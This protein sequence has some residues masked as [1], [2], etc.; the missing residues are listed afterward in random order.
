MIDDY[1]QALEKL[2]HWAEQAAEAGWLSRDDI[3]P[4]E[5]QDESQLVSLFRE[6]GEKPL[7]V[8]FFGGTGVGKSSLLNRL[9]GEDIA[10]TGVQRP[11]S[12]EVTLY[13]HRDFKDNLLPE[14]LPTEHTRIAWHNQDKRRFVAWLDLPDMDSTAREN[15]ALVEAW[16]PYIDWL[17]YVVSP[18]RYHDDLG[19]R[20][21]Q[22][23]G[24][25]HAWLFVMNHWDEGQPEQLEDFRDKLI[26]ENFS[27]PVILRTSCGKSIPD[28]DFPQLE[29]II[30]DAI[31]KHGLALLQS[32]GV[33]ARIDAARDQLAAW[34]ARLDDPERWQAAHDAW[35]Q[36]GQ[37]A[38]AQLADALKTSADALTLTLKTQQQGAAKALKKQLGLATD[39]TPATLTQTLWS[40][41]RHAALLD[42]LSLATGAAP[43]QSGLPSR[44]VEQR[45]KQ[46]RAQA[47]EIVRDNLQAALETALAKPGTPWQRLLYKLMDALSWLLPLAAASWAVFYLANTFRWGTLGEKAFLGID[48]AVHSGMMIAL[49]WF[50]P[51]WIK[52]RI[53]PSVVA[54]V[55]R[56]L[57]DGVTAAREALRDALETIWREFDEERRQIVDQIAAREETIGQ[58]KTN[59]REE[60]GGLIAEPQG[61][62]G[63]P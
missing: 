15:A 11:T 48:F 59:A 43:R 23:R 30:N 5:R 24:G 44:P 39:L 52:R 12:M 38:L 42:D 16:L 50:I 53:E 35:R 41:H 61:G 49:A 55:Q 25:R 3:A 29:A 26:Q 63:T 57:N 1:R 40:D 18:E 9:A 13:L 17:I 4:I 6:Q 58:L 47:P 46:F 51:W 19:W 60:V 8:A 28:D 21:L 34:R 14:N 27:N 22:Q 7:I 10:R 37:D 20:F 32:L 45:L 62:I 56:G 54:A 2:K 31:E 36:A 33:Q